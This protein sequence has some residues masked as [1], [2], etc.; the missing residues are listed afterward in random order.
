MKRHAHTLILGLAMLVAGCTDRQ[1]AERRTPQPGDTLYTAEK[2][3]SFMAREPE[4]AL[5]IIDSAVIVGNVS[6]F[7]ADFLRVKVYSQSCEWMHLDS[8]II[9]GERLMQHDSVRNSLDWRQNVLEVLVNACRLRGDNSQ[10]MR[11][12]TQ[13]ETVC[14]QQGSRTEALRTRAEIGLIQAELGHPNAGLALIDEVIDQLDGIRQFNELDAV[15]IAMK[16]KINILNKAERYEELIPVAQHIIDR[17]SDY[18]QNPQVYHDGSYREPTESRRDGY[19][20]FYQAQAYAFIASA[21]ASLGDMKN[22][23]DYL[24]LFDQSAYSQMF[25]GRW[26][27]API[28]CNL[29]GYG[30]ASA[31]CD[32]IE[33]KIGNDTITD[34]YTHLLRL[35]ASIAD[36]QGRKA[37]SSYFWHRYAQLSRQL[38]DSLIAGNGQL[39]AAR[40]HE[41]ELQQQIA[42]GQAKNRFVLLV[43]AALAIICLLVLWF[44]GYA[45]H[46]RHKTERRNSILIGQIAEAVKYKERY[47]E[48]KAS[49]QEQTITPPDQQEAE[50]EPP[51]P[52]TMNDEEMFAYLSEAIRREQ[53]FLDPNCGRQTIVE[54]FHITEHRVGS[55]FARGSNHTSLPDFIRDLRLEHACKLLAARPDLNIGEVASAA[56]FSNLT[57][58]GRDFKKKLDVTPSQYRAQLQG[59]A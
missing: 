12:S 47:H 17:L 56:G 16:R 8:A 57:V 34:N 40:Y 4:R 15:I 27:I 24:T 29:G 20:D 38:N 55:A 44:T 2:A 49:I 39:Y 32:E 48:L 31:I 42:D 9:I 5:Q 18:E 11:W 10:W 45:L 6:P 43:C 53:L 46:Q 50:A 13:L 35:R 51:S 21:Y 41:Q 36:A 19:I 25:S 59:K 1:V 28:L 30:R 23:R 33:A 37:A 14:E 22:A 3:M 54:R 26:L 58:F 52:D 7:M